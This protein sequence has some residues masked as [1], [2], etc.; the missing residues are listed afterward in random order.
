MG[1]E[2][3]RFCVLY[4]TSIDHS[5]R[6]FHFSK[7][8]SCLKSSS[9]SSTIPRI[10]I[11]QLDKIPGLSTSHYQSNRPLISIEIN[12]SKVRK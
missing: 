11:E 8:L 6:Q 2:G 10:Q 4:R 3:M 7:L 1:F 12:T 5:T 9:T